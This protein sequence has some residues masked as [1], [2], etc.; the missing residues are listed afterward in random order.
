VRWGTLFES[1]VADGR[2][3]WRTLHQSPAFVGVAVLSIA[4][5]VG[6]NTAIFSLVDQL[7]LRMLPV[8]RPQELVLL[9]AR[10]QQYGGGWGDGN[11]LSYPMYED[12]RD[13]NAVFTGMFARFS[14]ALSVSDG[15][16][17]ER[18]TSEL[19]SGSY[20]DLLGVPAAQ[21]R[22]IEQ[23]D[24]APD[25]MAV[26]VLSHSYWNGRFGA[27]PVILGR[28]LLIN[29]R[30]MTVVGVARQGFD[31]TNLGQAAQ[32]FIAIRQAPL[33]TPIATGLT[34]RRVRWVN[35]FGRLRPGLTP[36][37]AQAALQPFYASRLAVE[38]QEPA[39]AR[40]SATVKERFAK[41][42]IEVRAA[43]EGKS[44]LRRQFSRPLWVLMGIVAAVLLIACA[45][46]ANLLLA[47]AAARQ[48]EI[49]IRLAI[50]ASRLRIVQQLLFESL[51]LAL[52]GGA[53]GLLLARLAVGFLLT[54]FASPERVLTVSAEVD[55]RV[56]LF[57]L[58]A[59]AV[60][61][62]LF[63]LAPAWQSTATA[64]APTL[65]SEATGVAGGRVRHRRVLVISQLAI[66]LVLLNATGLFVR[67]LHNLITTESGIDTGHILSFYVTPGDNGYSAVRSRQLLKTVIDRLREAPGV[68]A[69][70]VASHSLLQGGS[71]NNNVTIEG[72]H[73]EPGRNRL[74][75]DNLVT[76]GYFDAMG[77][78]IVGGRDFDSRDER[79]ASDRPAASLESPVG[80]SRSVIV[81]DRFVKMFLGGASALGRH[82]GFG[83]DP[84][85]PTPLEIVGVVSDAKY[86]SVRDDIQPQLYMPFF[87][88][89]D[90]R[91]F[92]V[93]VRT[94]DDPERLIGTVRQILRDLD[95]TLPLQSL[96][97]LDEQ[98]NR[99]LTSERLLATLSV[100][101]SAVATLLAA[102]GLYSVIA[103]LVARRTREVGI[104]IALGALN[105]DVLWLVLRD[106]VSITAS[107]IAVALPLAWALIRFVRSQLYGIAPFDPSAI[108]FAMASVTVVAAIAGLMPARRA[109]RTNPT[110]ALRHD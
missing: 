5:G 53:A 22:V 29:N 64:I 38:V 33:L 31:G 58:V 77:M 80:P 41:G 7:V 36:P 56:L 90:A 93:N 13:Q 44:D 4:L 30:P 16:R 67:S 12:L 79:P 48:R 109:V 63:G 6:A 110:A 42:S 35:V 95:S 17:T 40:A 84:G 83:N 15:D 43:G 103:Y 86:T 102:I 101:F 62:V 74:T 49:A 89:P 104:R 46:V 91:G 25:A 81:N 71:W 60:T 55:G 20:F 69:V 82:I 47:R 105:T 72:L 18:V 100:F 85:T 54:F 75:L 61:G 34:S 92:V 24:D 57:T 19:I 23:R 14:V 37:Q 73:N 50:G 59:S 96:R 106:V 99:S 78:H 98:L 27:D 10:G 66:S 70:G 39:F 107:G 1:V 2:S 9:T 97:T 108:A 52:A 28:S 45:N 21:G 26:V 8:S 68:V 87:E 88:A 11:E 51:A 76:P 94:A 65:Q 32:L 3:A